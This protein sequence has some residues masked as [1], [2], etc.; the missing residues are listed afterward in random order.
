MSLVVARIA[1][2][3]R[4]ILLR[5]APLDDCHRKVGGFP[6]RGVIM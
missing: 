4:N 5:S 1:L 2:L 3:G 6:W